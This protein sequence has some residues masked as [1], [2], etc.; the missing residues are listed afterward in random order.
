MSQMDVNDLRGGAKIEIDTGPHVVTYVQFVKPGKGQ[1]FVKT[2]LRHLLTGRTIERTFRSTDKVKSA[3]VEERK[4][5]HLYE[6]GENAVFM[7]DNTFDQIEVSLSIVG[8]GKQWLKD[9]I[10]YELVFYNGSVVG[11]TPPNFMDL[12][13]TEC[14]PGV[15]GDTASGRVMKPAVL[16]TGAKVQV[17]I[18]VNQ[19]EKIKVDTRTAEYVSRSS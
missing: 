1:A 4:M 16:E 13:I 7:D 11:I 2:K 9:D 17:P 6:D 8:E 3:D 14:D 12:E 15:R 5:R 18:F 10:L 19:G